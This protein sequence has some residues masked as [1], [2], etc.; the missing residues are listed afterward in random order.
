MA[1]IVSSAIRSRM[2]A[3]IKGTNTKPELVV[4]RGLFRAGFRYILH[5][6][7]LP[8]KPDLVFPRYR[9]VVFIHGCFWH[10]HGCAL[11]KWPSSNVVFWRT[12]LSGNK[13][14]D[15]RN[16]ALLKAAG[17]R[18]LVIWECALKGPRRLATEA[19]IAR[20]TGWFRGS[21]AASRQLA[22]RPRAARQAS[23]AAIK[24]PSRKRSRPVTRE[25]QRKSG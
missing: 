20:V 17:W 24:L 19:M 23:L 10:C 18:T 9:S 1:D 11:F 22:G 7:R 2:M 25:K 15:R 12:K 21:A 4:R 6:K 16:L 5:D 3:G 8:G 14:L 13:K